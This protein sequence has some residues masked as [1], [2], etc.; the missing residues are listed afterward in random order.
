MISV[1]Y[2]GSAVMATIMAALFAGGTLTSP[3][4]LE[5]FI[6]GTFFLASAGAS[7]A[8]LTVSEI[9]P[10]ETRALAIAFFYAVGTAVGGI[11][12]PLLFGRLIASGSKGAVAVAFIIGAVVMAIGGIAEIFAGV[13]AEGKSLEE[14]ATPLSA[15]KA[16]DDDEDGGERERDG[17]IQGRIQQR[18]QR[19]RSG[20]PPLPPRTRCGG[21]RPGDAGQRHLS[22]RSARRANPRRG[23]RADRPR[24]RRAR[25]HASRRAR[26]TGRSAPLG[27]GALQQ[28]AP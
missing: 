20:C 24:R 16:E 19:E 2:L 8:Y 3:W 21:V 27:S 15:E 17:R 4:A 14:I 9:F 26:A 5:A 12:G 25:H 6:F 22:S 11:S 23:D 10:M 13:A 1:S 18:T 7:A 28:R